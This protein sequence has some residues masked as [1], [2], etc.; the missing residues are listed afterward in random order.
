MRYRNQPHE[1]G[2][3]ILF[4]FEHEGRIRDAFVPPD[5]LNAGGPTSLARDAI[6]Y[7]GRH[8]DRFIPAARRKAAICG[9]HA[10][11]TIDWVDL[12]P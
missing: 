10:M 1:F 8:P 6:S 5:L 3:G 12:R 11:L 4:S 7:V 2:G 9:P